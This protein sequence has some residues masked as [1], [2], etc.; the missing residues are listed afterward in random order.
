MYRLTATLAVLA[1]T[2]T[3]LPAAS[4]HT[5]PEDVARRCVNR[6]DEIV[7]R[8]QNA[9]AEETQECVRAIRRYLAAGRRDLAIR[10]ARE[11]VEAARERTRLCVVAVREVCI[12]CIDWLLARGADRLAARVR[13]VCA[14]AIEDLENLFERQKNAIE[15]ALQS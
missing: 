13:H 6:V 7:E 3:L 9:A 4:A 5:D 8:C 11:C 14:D 2:C 1:A 10:A 12:E 15:D